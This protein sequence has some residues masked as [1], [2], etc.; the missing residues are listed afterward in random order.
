M[1]SMIMNQQIM[2]LVIGNL[3]LTGV[4]C[5]YHW[6]GVIDKIVKEKL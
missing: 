4:L 1:D 2:K 3:L 6:E 5:V